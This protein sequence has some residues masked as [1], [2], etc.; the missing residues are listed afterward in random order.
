MGILLLILIVVLLVGAMPR[1]GYSRN[2]GYGPTGSLG[3][4]FV[5][6]LVLLLLGYLPRG[7]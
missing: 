5:I 2:W 4:V 3:L 1:W 7:F 6:L